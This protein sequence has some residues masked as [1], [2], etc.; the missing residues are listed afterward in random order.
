MK[1][2]FAVQKIFISL[3]KV[4]GQFKHFV[5]I[6]GQIIAVCCE[7]KILLVKIENAHSAFALQSS[8]KNS[9]F[10]I[11]LLR[12]VLAAFPQRAPPHLGGE[13]LQNVIHCFLRRAEHFELVTVKVN[14]ILVLVGCI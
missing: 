2:H 10:P 7:E 4:L 14:L 1:N 3:L 8:L 6:D 5:R 9:R 12:R 11:K 13:Q